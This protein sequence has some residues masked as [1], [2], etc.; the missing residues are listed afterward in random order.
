MSRPKLI[1]VSNRLPINLYQSSEGLS[2]KSS[3]SGG[4]L[5][6]ALSAVFDQKRGIWVGWTGLRRSIK[7]GEL[8]SLH[9]PRGL[10]PLTIKTKL[11]DHYY[12]AF[13][14]QTLWPIFHGIKPHRTYN[15]ADWEASLTVNRQ[16]AKIIAENAAP[17]D[18]IWIQDFHLI[19]LPQLLRAA[20]LKNRIGYFLHTPFPEPQFL[21]LI[22]NYRDL[23]GSLSQA[24]LVG[25][26][27]ERDVVNF[28][29]GI[30]ELKLPEPVEKVGAFPIGINYHKYYMARYLTE[31]EKYSKAIKQRYKGQ[32]IIYSLSRLDYTKG[33]INQLRAVEALLEK[34][35][36]R[37][38]LIYKLVVAPSREDLEEYASLK[39]EI[40]ALVR[41]I[42]RR[43]GAAD[44]Q[45]V[46]Y[47]YR[48]IEFAEVIG[49]YL[50]ADVVLVTPLID[51]MNL[52]AKEYVAARADNEGVLV[53]SRTAGVAFQLTEAVLVDPTDVKKIS[54]GLQKALTM[55]RDERLRRNKALRQN[56]RRENVF[57]WAR[58]FLEALNDV[59]N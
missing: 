26:Q 1:I 42:N 18:L 41:Q 33:I 19:M 30:K 47:E 56:V 2:Y 34:P 27:T 24:D 50:R 10:K 16:F 15:A 39:G 58:S 59:R 17:G 8:A 4:G 28:K 43:F 5:A 35:K 51:G 40:E 12:Y 49:W 36:W 32:K 53:L 37:S 21:K 22:P 52:I 3:T 9:L 13:S 54:G 7:A 57:N 20:G 46:D 11:F 45:P 25:F 48:T 14:N 44:W 29:R 6:A 23:V 38:R 55:P 31:V